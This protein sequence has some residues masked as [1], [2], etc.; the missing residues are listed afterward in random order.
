MNRSSFHHLHEPHLK[1][2]DRVKLYRM[3]TPGKRLI[4]CLDGTW[5]NSDQGYNRPTLDQPNATLQV[6]T[7][8]T[9]VY[10]ALR[11]RDSAGWAQVMY[12]HPGVGSNGGIADAFAGGVF[13]VGV[14]EVSDHSTFLE[15][16]CLT[17]AE[18]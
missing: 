13:G 9:R 17:V 4:L 2:N 7:N 18:Y 10:R 14:S 11:K 6:P 3:F 12:Y 1:I 5:V 16:P 15:D 8:V